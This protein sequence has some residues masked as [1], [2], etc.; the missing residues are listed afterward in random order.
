MK[1]TPKIKSAVPS[2]ETVASNYHFLDEKKFVHFHIYFTDST[3]IWTL[4][5]RRFVHINVR[6]KYRLFLNY[7]NC[8][9]Q[10]RNIHIKA[11]KSLKLVFFLVR[12]Q[13]IPPG[14]YP[15]T[16]PESSHLSLLPRSIF[17]QLSCVANH[18][19]KLFSRNGPEVTPNN[20][21]GQFSSIFVELKNVSELL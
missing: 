20:K 2:N 15:W 8:S 16:L 17:N 3:A 13:L 4:L 10:F 12:C 21:N 5:Y 6:K 7:E 19:Q 9:Q 11:L 18:C 1:N 14:L